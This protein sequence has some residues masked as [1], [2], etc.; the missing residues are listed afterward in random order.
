MTSHVEQQI[1]ARLA[2]ARAEEDRKRKQ[3]EELARRR[4]AGVA[5][6]NARRLY[7]LAQRGLELVPRDQFNN[8][9]PA[10]SGC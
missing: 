8:A 1:A 2:K 10:A 7:N 9:S 3:R 6:R 5:K 4:A